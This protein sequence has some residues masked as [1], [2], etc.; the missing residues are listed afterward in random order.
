[1]KKKVVHKYEWEYTRTWRRHEVE[2]GERYFKEDRPYD[3]LEKHCCTPYGEIIQ[4]QYGYDLFYKAK[5][6]K[7]GKTVKE[8][9]LYAENL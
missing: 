2:N 6:V 1:M 4:R 5:K 9:K 8:L 7:H 3:Y